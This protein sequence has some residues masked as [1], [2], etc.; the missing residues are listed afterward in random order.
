MIPKG[1]VFIMEGKRL[2]ILRER[3][4][5]SQT[6]FAIKIG[7]SKQTLYKYENNLI[8]NVPSDKIELM[9]ELLG[10]SPAY[11]MGWQEE[12]T[13]E[14]AERAKRIIEDYAENGSDAR[15]T[16]TVEVISEEDK[17]LLYRLHKV[18]PST[19][20]SINL[21]IEADLHES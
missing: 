19:L 20:D 16:D 7:E 14:E 1:A 18:R 6:D 5:I 3:L 17:L 8:T 12:P 2:K 21:L 9:A 15:H 11:L 13:P 10:C 4:G